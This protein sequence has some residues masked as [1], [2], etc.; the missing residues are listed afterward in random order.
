MDVVPTSQETVDPVEE[1]SQNPAPERSPEEKVPD[2]PRYQRRFFDKP[3]D[4]DRSSISVDEPVHDVR[5]PPT[6]VE[7]PEA[8]KTAKA[9]REIEDLL[10]DLDILEEE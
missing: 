2:E 8:S 6:E 5:P 4:R 9:S 7:V 10:N 1:P 3:S